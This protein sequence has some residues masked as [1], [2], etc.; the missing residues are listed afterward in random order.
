MPV[1]FTVQNSYSPTQEYQEIPRGG[2]PGVC[3][4][5]ANIEHVGHHSEHRPYEMG[6]RARSSPGRVRER[7]QHGEAG[8][9]PDS[10]DHAAGSPPTIRDV[11]NLKA[12]VDYKALHTRCFRPRLTRLL[13]SVQQYA[14]IGDVIFGASQNLLACGVWSL[15]RISLLTICKYSAYLE[16]VSVLFMKVG[17]SAPL[18]QEMASLFPH[19]K[20]LQDLVTRYFVTVVQI[21]QKS[22]KFCQ[23]Q[24]LLNQMKLFTHD[25]DISHYELELGRHANAIKS[26]VQIEHT[27]VSSSTYNSV[28]A[29][30]TAY[31]RDKDT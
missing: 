9:I 13:E 4:V 24:S 12:E 30:S 18:L 22:L 27:K 3:F 15:V 17:Q 23:K 20:P 1:T 8:W 5:W 21:C 31:T 29:L 10:Q 25:G 7:P 14:S 19:S 6:S 26:Q 28:R 11:M 2:Y 16:K